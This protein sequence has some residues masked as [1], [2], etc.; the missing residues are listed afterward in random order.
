MA[1]NDDFKQAC[2]A[3]LTEALS[4]L[5]EKGVPAKKDI[6]AFFYDKGYN[7]HHILKIDFDRLYI[8]YRDE[9]FS[10]PQYRQ[11]IEIVANT[12]TLSAVLFADHEG[13]I[14][15]EAEK[16]QS[17][18]QWYLTRFLSEYLRTGLGSNLKF[19]PA[20]FNY[21]YEKLERYILSHRRFD[22]VWSVHLR[23][24]TC[25]INNIR[26][27][28]Y[29]FIRLA[30]DEEKV[31]AL[32]KDPSLYFDAPEYN[33]ISPGLQVAPD[34]PNVFL[35]IHQPLERLTERKIIPSPQ[36]AM[37]LAPRVV[38]ALRL[39]KSNPVGIASYHWSVPEQPFAIH[40]RGLSHSIVLHP[41]AYRGD[42]YVLTQEDAD[43]LPK[44]WS[45]IKKAY[46]SP[47]LSTA[48]A[49][50]EDS[51]LRT[52]SEDKLIDYWIA[53]ESLFFSLI[54][55]EYVGSM[56]ETVASTISFYLGK[57]Q[58]ERRS[59]YEFIISSHVARGYFV[60]GHRGQPIKNL[61]LVVNKT[62]KY[63]RMALRKRIEDES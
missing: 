27:D 10:I 56:G 29:T 45:G 34:I 25:D 14:P 20:P 16:Q 61:E 30:T 43:A 17:V 42:A 2:E 47:E 63:L 18:L 19:S 60:H 52:K 35:D 53:L 51:Y 8:T 3:W 57:T 46:T 1:Q 12:P 31:E 37:T 48:I 41:F 6:D 9:L 11:I 55:K 54:S 21:I 38:L 22:G 59:I 24:V 13:K 44:L 26:L 32:R 33:Q 40:N 36:E 5:A 49:R 50:F 58:S 15:S 28:R 39:L 4:Y 7:V 23:N 62:E